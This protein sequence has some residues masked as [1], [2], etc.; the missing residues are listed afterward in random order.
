MAVMPMQ[1]QF[2]DYAGRRHPAYNFPSQGARASYSSGA[3]HQGWPADY[4]GDN[5]SG[6]NRMSTVELMV[7]M[8]CT[9]CEA[10]V[11]AVLMAM[12]G[13]RD[14]VTDP[15]TQRVIVTGYA[16]DPMRALRQVK[17]VNENAA[18]WRDSSS[19][20]NDMYGD[21]DILYHRRYSQSGSSRSPRDQSSK[22]TLSRAALDS[23][24][25]SN[26]VSYSTSHCPGHAG[27]TSTTHFAISVPDHVERVEFH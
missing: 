1:Q 12:E 5:Y 4:H 13:V 20:Q 26:N 18:L 17:H 3:S 21:D 9:K 24:I 8:C 6:R 7:P 27:S 16:V 25:S 23:G 14:V 10:Q 15:Y 11:R 2:F 22:Q 19:T